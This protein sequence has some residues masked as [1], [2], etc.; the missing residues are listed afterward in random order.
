[1]V[2]FYEEQKNIKKAKEHID[3]VTDQLYTQKENQILQDLEA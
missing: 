2:K 3:K 1:M